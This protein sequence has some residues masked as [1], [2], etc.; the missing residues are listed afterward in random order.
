[1]RFGSGAGQ[2]EAAPFFMRKI[3]QD[4]IALD[5]FKIW[6]GRVKVSIIF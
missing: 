3:I 6:P 4:Q 2:E 1:M 5:I